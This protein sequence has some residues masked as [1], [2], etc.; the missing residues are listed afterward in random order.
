M[1]NKEYVFVE[2]ISN[3]LGIAPHYASDLSD[4]FLIQQIEESKKDSFVSPEM[5]EFFGMTHTKES[6]KL[7]SESAK[8][9]PCNRKGAVLSENTKALISKNNAAKKTIKTPCGIFESKVSAAKA[10]NTTPESIREILNERLDLPVKRKGKLFTEDH[11][12]KTPRELGW[13]YV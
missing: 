2:N 3:I 13:A 9:R 1:K 5:N 4:S 10:M 8:K 6:R 7:M 11:I 12:G